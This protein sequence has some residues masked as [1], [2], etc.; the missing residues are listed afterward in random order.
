MTAAGDTGN[1]VWSGST[2]SVRNVTAQSCFMA[3]PICP[4]RSGCQRSP[5]RA[6]AG[7]V[8]SIAPSKQCHAVSTMP[9]CLSTSVPEHASQTWIVP[10]AP[11]LI[12]GT[13]I[14]R[15]AE[16]T[17][18]CSGSPCSA[19]ECSPTPD[20]SV[21]SLMITVRRR[22]IAGGVQTAA[23]RDRARDTDRHAMAA[24]DACSWCNYVV[25]RSGAFL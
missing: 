20:M 17:G 22:L 15:M 6:R 7:R 2:G 19:G 21:S 1:A 3:P 5:T 8:K 24:F 10:P 11:L 25:G 23:G 12:R 18:L 13:L 4:S 16:A 9:R 14:C